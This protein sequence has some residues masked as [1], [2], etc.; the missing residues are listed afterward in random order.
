MEEK[1]FKRLKVE[2]IKKSWSA[3]RIFAELHV[4]TVMAHG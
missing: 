1:K 3:E 4:A 2:K